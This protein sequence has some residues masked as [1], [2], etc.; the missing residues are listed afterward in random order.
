M[1]VVF[2][3]SPLLP[4]P[5]SVSTLWVGHVS[6]CLKQI[7]RYEMCSDAECERRINNSCR[8]WVLVL[9]HLIRKR[10]TKNSNEFSLLIIERLQFLE[11]MQ[12]DSDDVDQLVQFS[13]S[14]PLCF[15][16]IICTLICC[17]VQLGSL[18]PLALKVCFQR[19]RI[20]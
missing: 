11:P 12:Y 1:Q 19:K 10:S 16:E 17:L 8:I 20:S 5:P 2:S 18:T 14:W 9:Y 3:S 6:D 4:P 13:C 7:R 15:V